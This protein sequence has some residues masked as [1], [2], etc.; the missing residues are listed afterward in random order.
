MS[1]IGEIVEII[2][3]QVH[4]LMIC[5]QMI[6]YFLVIVYLQFIEFI[7]FFFLLLPPRC[8]SLRKVLDLHVWLLALLDSAFGI[9]IVYCSGDSSNTIIVT[10]ACQIIIHIPHL[11]SLP[12]ITHI[13]NLSL[14][15]T[16]QSH[17]I[18]ITSIIR[19]LTLHYLLWKWHVIT[20]PQHLSSYYHIF[21]FILIIL[22]HLV[23]VHYWWMG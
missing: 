9:I 20:H 21:A 3:H 23:L 2:K 12:H 11:L 1:L 5:C 13:I 14:N 22:W 8:S 16:T 18:P 10:P 17:L 6:Y 4:V 15:L 7:M 19:L